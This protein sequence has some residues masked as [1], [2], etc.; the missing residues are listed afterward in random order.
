[1]GQW[2]EPSALTLEDTVAQAV[3]ALPASCSRLWVALSGGRDSVALLHAAYRSVM[4]HRHTLRLHAVH[5]NHHLQPAAQAFEHT[6]QQVC[7]AR[8]IPLIVCNVDIEDKRGGL[9]QAARFARYEAFASLLAHDDVLWLAHHADDQ[10]ETFLL[11]V[12]RGSGTKGLSA[13]PAKRALGKGILERP[14]L[15]LSQ[16]EVANYANAQ[17]LSWYDDPSNDEL[18]FDRNYLRH[19][20]LPLLKARWPQATSSICQAATQSRESDALLTQS[21][22]TLLAQHAR[23]DQL[24]VAVMLSQPEAQQRLIIRR[25]LER[26]SLPLPP[27]A[28]L[29]TLLTQ[30]SAGRGEVR[31]SG[32]IARIWRGQL[33]LDDDAPVRLPS[34]DLPVRWGISAT[35]G[36][37]ASL[38]L[39]ARQGGERINIRGQHRTLKALFQEY[40]IPP[41]QRASFGIV[42]AEG[43]PVALL[44]QDLAL[45]ADNWWVTQP[46]GTVLTS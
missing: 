28:R 4:Q 14:L 33:Y 27:R 34:D 31:W 10:A 45:I 23:L 41:W 42:K 15:C 29:H 43:V 11:R 6:C 35:D 3:H 24:S 46:Q 25:A 13:M 16:T 17:A 40:S 8:D 9:E 1:M 30:L 2:T 5:V 26:L 36:H 37:N 18:H 20:V 19:H 44:S 12:M 7:D 21:A 39:T 32:G 22:D 38:V